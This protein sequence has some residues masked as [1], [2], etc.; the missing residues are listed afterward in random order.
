MSNQI[1][2]LLLVVVLAA[3]G[4]AIFYLQSLK[5]ANPSETIRPATESPDAATSAIEPK[6]LSQNKP[7][8]EKN[9]PL[10]KEIIDPQGFINT[11]KISLA[12]LIGKKVILV[13]FWTYSCINC[14]RTT[15]YLNAW[16]D[17]YRDQGLE[18]V[19]IH[20]P[21]FDFE[22]KY[23]NVTA[24]VKKFGIKYPVVL[25][26]NYATWTAY[27]N[28][29]WPRKY[30][31]DID[32]FIVY[33]HIGEGAYDET[34]KKI[35]DLLEE[36]MTALNME[37]EIAKDIAKPGDAPEVDFAKI[38]SPETYFGAARNE[39]LGN[40]QAKTLGLQSLSSPREVKPNMLYLSGSWQ[41]NREFA[42]SK[43]S[44][45]KIIFRYKAKS[46]Y[47]V[48]SADQEIALKIM[49]DGQPVS[50]AIAG[51]DLAKDSN[52]SAKVRE[53]RLYKLI[54]DSAYGEHTIE[55]TIDKPGF[56]AF[57]FTFG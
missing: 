4:G 8:K 39:N 50:A 47:L 2:S 29:Y 22:K 7:A 35:Q 5:P 11:P 32:G 37:G 19:G 27:G 41:F 25:D 49:R 42:E 26:N 9:Y 10:A 34:E 28:R 53:D 1:R 40:G 31:I 52:S 56:R 54:E 16:Y 21:E 12:D 45:A 57:A 17:K 44:S 23:E 36:R 6:N 48:A 3:I 43:S 38:Q 13:D 18:I 15:P 20:T 33:D 30:L 55:I 24:A 14:Q 51:L 46:V